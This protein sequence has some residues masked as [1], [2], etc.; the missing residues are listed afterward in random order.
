MNRTERF[1]RIDQ[2][3]ISHKL[4]TRKQ[5]LDDLGV[6]WATLKRDLAYLKDRFNAPIIFDYQAGGYRFDKP[7][8]GPAY[9]LPGLWFNADE[10]YA[11]LT[12][13]QLLSNLEPGLLAP[14]VVP[15]LA[16]LN[17]ILAEN[18]PGFYAVSER[19]QIHC[20]GK[21]R[22]NPAYFSLVSRATLEHR[23]LKVRHYSR[24]QDHY[25][26][27][28]LS[29]QRLMFYRNNW[30]LDAWCHQRQ[31]LRRFSVDAFEFVELLTKPAYDVTQAEL[32]A[33][34]AHSY[35]VYAGGQTCT[36]ILR[37]S[38]AA[39]R[40]VADENWHPN[41]SGHYDSKGYFVLSV[42]YTKSD[43]LMMD[44]LRHGRHVEVLEP[45]E[46]RQSVMALIQQ[47]SQ[48]YQEQ[49]ITR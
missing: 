1:Y 37:F 12:M 29:P 20:I 35:G 11:L 32:D 21:R 25:S 45:A 23:Q 10:T 15:L 3:L 47:M 49:E 39:A 17:G 44:I 9:E 26:D 2:L 4:L 33:E 43:E 24:Q 48:L 8:A 42:P 36:A 5:L 28:L 27:R 46:L 40:W 31:A 19:I 41:Q 7:N 18:T 13:H 16:R 22:K 30:Y 6:S 38:P 34:F 14:H